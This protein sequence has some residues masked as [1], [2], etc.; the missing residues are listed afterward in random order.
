M[1]RK[2]FGENTNRW[3]IGKEWERRRGHDEIQERYGLA[4][5]YCKECGKEIG[6]YQPHADADD[7]WY[8]PKK[9]EG[10]QCAFCGAVGGTPF[11]K[12]EEGDEE[13]TD[14]M[15]GIEEEVD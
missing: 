9:M 2:R 6:G 13:D 7:V 3:G 10:M 4:P 12:G 1:S 15:E 14:R 8:G 5:V 11:R